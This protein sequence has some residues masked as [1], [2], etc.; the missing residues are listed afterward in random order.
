MSTIPIVK[1][2]TEYHPG[3]D[4]WGYARFTVLLSTD[5]LALAGEPDTPEWDTALGLVAEHIKKVIGYDLQGYSGGPGRPF[6]SS[7]SV[8]PAEWDG[9]PAA[10]IGS[11]FGR[12]V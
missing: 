6:R 12:D 7:P 11:H 4:D 9:V 3:Q 5:L 2:D 1:I 8:Q 10:I